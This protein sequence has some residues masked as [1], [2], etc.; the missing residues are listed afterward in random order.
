MQYHSAGILCICPDSLKLLILKGK[1]H[2]KWSFP[3]GYI[4][5]DEDI[6]ST[7]L[8]E[9]NE[10]IGVQL[11]SDSIISQNNEHLSLECNLHL[12]KPIKKVP[13]GI[14]RICFYMTYMHENTPIQLSREHSQYR[15]VH[16]NDMKTMSL[17]YEYIEIAT[18][19]KDSLNKV[20][21]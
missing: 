12:P 18:Q 19:A 6:L 13:S 2:N 4:E 3:K 7:A 9:L 14:K 16:I 15:W 20:N 8:R 17:P 10:E 1:F 21:T 11:H 5:K